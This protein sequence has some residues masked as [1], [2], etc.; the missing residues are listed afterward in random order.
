[1]RERPMGSYYHIRVVA[2]WHG[3]MV[4]QVRYRR[5]D[6]RGLVMDIVDAKGNV[7]NQMWNKRGQMTQ[8]S[9]CSGYLT[10]MRYDALDR[11]TAVTLYDGRRREYRYT[12]GGRLESVKQPDDC[13]HPATA[14]CF[15]V[16]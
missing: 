13:K 14:Y 15:P 4:H 11:L 5:Y 7:L 8:F 1:M 12:P 3:K 6:D 16:Q 9:D 2:N 10:R